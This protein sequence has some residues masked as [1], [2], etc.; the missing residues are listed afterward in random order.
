MLLVGFF[1]GL[2]EDGSRR[3][4][5]ASQLVLLS[6]WSRLPRMSLLE[7]SGTDRQHTGNCLLMLIEAGIH[8]YFEKNW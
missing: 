7:L 3:S 1:Q 6:V 2:V 8:V 4:T 5:L